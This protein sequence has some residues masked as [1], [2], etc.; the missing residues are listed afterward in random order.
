MSIVRPRNLPTKILIKTIKL[1]QNS[2][3]MTQQ[4]G[5]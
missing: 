3:G 4:K 2:L 5:N 1:N